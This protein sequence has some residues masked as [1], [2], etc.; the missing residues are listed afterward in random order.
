M[1]FRRVTFVWALTIAIGGGCASHASVESP[2]SPERNFGSPFLVQQGQFPLDWLTVT[3]PNPVYRF[4]VGSDGAMYA[5][6]GTP[7]EVVERVD[8]ATGSITVDTPPIQ[9]YAIASG[10]D[11]N[12]WMCGSGT[13]IAS[14][15][16][17]GAFTTYD[18]GSQYI[19]HDMVSGPDGNLWIDD[20][21]ANRIGRITTS[22][23]AMWYSIT[24]GEVPEGI[25]A[26][27][28]GNMYVSENQ[29]RGRSAIAR[30]DTNLQS[31][32]EFRTKAKGLSGVTTASDGSIYAGSFTNLVRLG[33]HGGVSIIPLPTSNYVTV[34][35]SVPSTLLYLAT[36]GTSGPAFATFGIFSHDLTVTDLPVTGSSPLSGV[37]PGPDKNVWTAYGDIYVHLNRVITPSQ[38]SLTILAGATTGLQASETGCNCDLTA[39]SANPSIAKVRESRI[40]DNQWNVTGVSVGTTTISISDQAKNSYVIPVTVH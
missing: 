23:I 34:A 2:V 5:L 26:G 3:S 6:A 14:M 39:A 25:T 17:G 32:K 24:T 18:L 35:H 22:G 12:I 16:T 8:V 28:D 29:T 10:P 1:D 7:N 31:Y 27:L 20:L 40:E 21:I 15:T 11:G 38:T 33:K 4:V 36:Y 30:I 13:S 9:I 37:T 19:C